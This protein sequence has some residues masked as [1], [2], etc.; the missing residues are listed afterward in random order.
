MWAFWERE[1]TD[2]FA[3]P[4][5]TILDSASEPDLICFTN[6]CLP[7]KLSVGNKKEPEIATRFNISWFLFL[8]TLLSLLFLLLF[9][10]C[11][12]ALCSS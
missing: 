5:W 11:S 1:G 8:S 7:C 10:L 3:I 6:C 2:L 12:L 9:F 4:K